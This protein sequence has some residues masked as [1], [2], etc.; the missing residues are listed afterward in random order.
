MD[1]TLCAAYNYVFEHEFIE[2]SLVRLRF[3]CRETL[4]GSTL[5]VG[6]EESL[7]LLVAVP[8]LQVVYYRKMVNIYTVAA[9]ELVSGEAEVIEQLVECSTLP[10]E[11]LSHFVVLDPQQE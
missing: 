10:G 11:V 2:P 6:L 1:S 3:D 7:S 5:D 9:L 8:T 4:L